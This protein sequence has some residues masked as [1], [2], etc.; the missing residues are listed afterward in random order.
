[1]SFRQLFATKSLEHVMEEVES[2]QRLKRALGPWSLVALGIG[3]IIGT[4]IFVLVGLILAG[5]WWLARQAAGGSASAAN[6]AKV[7]DQS[8][9]SGKT[10]YDQNEPAKAIGAFQAAL[11]LNPA[12]PDAHLNLGILYDMYMGKYEEAKKIYAL[13]FTIQIACDNAGITRDQWYRRKRMEETGVDR[14]NRE[15]Y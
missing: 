5:A 9:A 6:S 1:M 13:G 14:I 8:M 11:A 10:F 3:A 4:G 7:F 15:Y 2:G 12:N